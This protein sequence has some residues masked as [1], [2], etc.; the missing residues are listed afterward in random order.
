MN[1]P[2]LRYRAYID[3][4]RA[5]AVL[6][7]LFFHAELGF[8]GGYVGV[9]VFF[10]ISGYLITAL[11]LKDLDG[12]KFRILDF[13]ERRIRRIMPAL[14]V[15]VIS[16]IVVGWFVYLPLDFKELGQS[17]L[18]QAALVSNIY[19]WRQS[20]YFEQAVEVKPLLHTWSL[21]VEEQ[22]YL[23]FPC[24]LIAF[25]RFSRKSIVPF[26]VILCGASFGLSVWGTYYYPQA[27]YY[28][29]PT[30]AWELLIG[31]FLAVIPAQR[32]SAR[33]LTELLSWGGLLA[34]LW[35]VFFYDKDTR[36]PGSAAILPCVGAGLIIWANGRDLTSVGKILAL[37]PVVF[38][39]LI[40]YSLYLWHWPVLVFAGYW[41][42]EP[43]P[44]GL[45]ILLL[46][47]CLVLAILS[48]RYVETPFRKRV[49]F[50]RRSSIFAFGGITTVMFMLAGMAI[51]YTSGAPSRLPDLALQYAAG[52]SDFPMKNEV[53][54]KGAL[55]GSFMELGKSCKNQ[56]IKILVWGDSHAMAI[57]PGIDRLCNEYGV[58]GVAATHSS[59]APLIG[60]KSQASN[61]KNDCIPFNDAI[62]SFIKRETVSDVLLAAAWGSY[63]SRDKTTKLLH[64]GLHD[65]IDALK[66]TN[67]R[68]W[69]MRDVP[70]QLSNIPKTLA[71]SVW[72]GRGMP[73]DYG[74]PLADYLG[75]IKR[76]NPIFEGVTS[77]NNKVFILDTTTIFYDHKKI[78]RIVE[79]GKALYSDKGHLTTPGSHMLRPIFEPIFDGTK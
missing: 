71:S 27:T 29:L 66:E 12:G 48:W 24:L 18:A 21:A 37:R 58:R 63:I 53:S 61:L 72:H 47:A 45:R 44:P 79:N 40:S 17:V 4:L 70:I 64:R 60:Y 50:D 25:R 56:P 31:S 11:I 73:D 6:P 5:L 55:E 38:I 65:T 42:F 22:F 57:L 7:V 59:T 68:I 10:V 35:A 14:A 2:S 74:L 15:V 69:I 54:M 43:I 19:F 39:G 20:G 9:D 67:V 36:F 51:H 46:L 23:F 78:C 34:I 52:A 32:T 49:V 28:L 8:P 16:C 26:I 75:Q 30:R 1:S 33:W 41:A 62:L 13:W 3:G 76:Q 77:I